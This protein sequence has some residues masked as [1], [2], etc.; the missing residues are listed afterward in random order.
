M[1]MKN[2]TRQIILEAVVACIEKFGLEKVTTR[3]I[4][5]EAGTNIASI[6]YYFRSKDELI[7][8]T[9]AMT[10]KHMLQDVLLAVNKPELSFEAST[11][12]VVFYLLD[13]GRRF[14]G[15]TKAHLSMVIADGNRNSVSAR[16]MTQVFEGLVNRAEREFPNVK[17]DLLRLRV[18][19]MMTSIMFMMLAPGFI[20]RSPKSRPT[21][22]QRARDLAD[23]YVELLLAGIQSLPQG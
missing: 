3:K 14:P 4:A 1:T 17:K 2:T 16:V 12:D 21:S 23:S 19:Q 6:N 7:A 22:V 10:I 9:L 8:E 15:I 5:R 18:L 13:G 11:R 20:S